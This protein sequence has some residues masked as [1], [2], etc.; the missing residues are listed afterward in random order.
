MIRWLSRLPLIAGWPI[1]PRADDPS[2]WHGWMVGMRAVSVPGMGRV[3]ATLVDRRVLNGEE[4]FRPPSD[5]TMREYEE[6][7]AI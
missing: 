3:T 1:G 7:N 2:M 5:D 4:Q 6:F